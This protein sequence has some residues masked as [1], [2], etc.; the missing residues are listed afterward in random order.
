VNPIRGARNG[1]IRA[2]P[3]R[4]FAITAT[5]VQDCSD[6]PSQY[7]L[8]SETRNASD[9]RATLAST[10]HSVWRRVH[11]DKVKPMRLPFQSIQI[12][13]FRSISDKG[14][15]LENIS[16]LNFLCGQN[17]SGKSNILTFVQ[18]LFNHISRNQIYQ[19]KPTDYHQ[20]GSRRIS[21]SIV[22]DRDFMCTHESVDS[23]IR[24]LYRDWA[25]DPM[26]R[27]NYFVDEKGTPDFNIGALVADTSHHNYLNTE[28]WRTYLRRIVN[29][30][31]GDI[32]SWIIEI[33]K[34]AHPLNFLNVHADLIP[35]L[36]T[37][38]EI[39]QEGITI[40]NNRPHFG[41]RRY[42]GGMGTIDLL[43]HNQH[44]PVGQESLLED[45]RKVQTFLRYITG[46]GSAEIEIPADKSALIVNID[47]KR[48]PIS[49][50][51]TGI[52]ELVIISTAAVNFHNQVVCI[53]EPE[54]HIHPLLQRKFIE[55]LQKETDNIY[56]IATHS[57]HILDA[58]SASVWPAPGLVDTR[59]S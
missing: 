3:R 26:P 34:R 25:K 15:S 5:D 6:T 37:L 48:L 53:E 12:C 10:T 28:Q 2:R 24:D 7:E 40:Q 17:N 55:F 20:G 52:E 38:S 36:R 18:L 23:N 32:R 29:A 49:S 58:S 57:P 44:P 35:A 31:G 11:V 43:F 16:S 45:F 39:K 46:N 41:G 50:L 13:G 8:A 47:G 54:L 33:F 59:L 19:F 21:F 22:P 14:L 27:F 4:I 9:N 1:G 56:F 51:G 42:F 30:S